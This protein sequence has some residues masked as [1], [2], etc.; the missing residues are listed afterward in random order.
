MTHLVGILNLTPDSFSDGGQFFDPEKAIKRAGELFGDGAAIVDIGAE[1]T[2]PTAIPLTSDEEW[3]RL[4]HVLPALLNQYPGKISLDSYHPETIEKALALGPIIVN[5]VTGL[6]NPTMVELLIKNQPRVIIS[7]LPGNDIQAAHH[8]KLI[9]DAD[10][11]KNELL[12]KAAML[13]AAGY[14]TSHIILDPGIGFGK[15]S[16]LNRELLSFAQ[17]VPDYA[18][19]IG[20]SRKRF[21]GEN[22]MELAPNIEAGKIA[23]E[24]GTVYLRVHDVKGH[25]GYLFK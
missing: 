19:M 24:S 16:R 4:E 7:H 3:Q 23:R 17:L 13:I 15:T 8:G 10:L 12:Q 22:R 9:D 25:A 18:V 11:V 20:Y 6:T 5:D 1:S 2:R 21:L 14:E